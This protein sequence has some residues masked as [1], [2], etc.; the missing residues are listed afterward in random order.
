MKPESESNKIDESDKIFSHQEKAIADLLASEGKTV[1]SL[2]E[3]NQGRT[4]D[5][6]VDGIP[7]EF[8]S[9]V[10]GATNS[11]VK[12]LINSSIRRGG[13]ARKIIIDARGSGLTEA[14]ANLGLQRAKNVSRGKIDS[15]RI[16]GDGY[17]LISNDF[18]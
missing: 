9:L 8:K 10:I 6:E 7:T 16:I 3:K 1:K 17:D 2:L 12:N 11:T 13:Q 4:A 18:Q 5:A 15:V 14:E